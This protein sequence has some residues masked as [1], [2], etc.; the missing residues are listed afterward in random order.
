MSAFRYVY[1]RT[2]DKCAH[3]LRGCCKR[4]AAP[5]PDPEADLRG[6]LAE[7]FYAV[8]LRTPFGSIDQEGRG[9]FNMDDFARAFG[10]VASPPELASVFRLI[11]QDR[12]GTVTPSEWQAFHQRYDPEYRRGVPRHTRRRDGCPDFLEYGTLLD[13]ILTSCSRFPLREKL[14]EANEPFPPSE[15]WLTAAMEAEWAT[16]LLR[17][18]WGYARNPVPDLSEERQVPDW[19]GGFTVRDEGHVGMTN[20]DFCRTE[21]AVEA[22]LTMPEVVGLRLYT[23]PG[24]EA[25][26]L[27]LRA[28]SQRFPVTQYCIDSAIGKLAQV[29]PLLS[30]LRGMRKPMDPRWVRLYNLYRGLGRKR[31]A[32]S[33]PGFV[34]ATTDLAVATGQDFGGPLLFALHTM[35]PAVLPRAGFLSNGG[36]VQWVS[37]YPAEAEVLLP[38]NVILVPRLLCKHM[39]DHGLPVPADKSVFQFLVFFPWDFAH[40][41]PLVTTDF[42]ACANALLDHLHGLDVATVQTCRAGHPGGV[43]N[44]S[45]SR[46]PYPSVAPQ[47]PDPDCADPRDAASRRPPS[48]ATSPT[49]GALVQ[50][51]NHDPKPRNPSMFIPSV[52]P[53]QCIFVAPDLPSLPDPRRIPYSDLSSVPDPVRLL[54][55][56]RPTHFPRLSASGTDPALPGDH[57]HVAVAIP[58]PQRVPEAGDLSR[59]HPSLS[60]STFHDAIDEVTDDSVSLSFSDLSSDSYFLQP[61]HPVPTP[62]DALQGSDVLRLGR[63]PHYTLAE[64]EQAVAALQRR[65]RYSDGLDEVGLV[66]HAFPRVPA[67]LHPFLGSPWDVGWWGLIAAGVGAAVGSVGLSVPAA[68]GIAA[69]VATTTVVASAV[70]L[71]TLRSADPV[72]TTTITPTVTPTQTNPH[73]QTTTLSFTA[74]QT[75][76]GTHT[77]TASP[78]PTKPRTIS[79]TPT[80]SVTPSPSATRSP[81][82]SA[83]STRTVSQ[84]WTSSRTWIPVTSVSPVG[85]PFPSDSPSPSAN[86]SPSPPAS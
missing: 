49:K 48:P 45:L 28:N 29:G 3:F 27:S 10:W 65:P 64:V 39:R 42:L 51:I 32:L 54:R 63:V 5:D 75:T 40:N 72:R 7:H 73:S 11:N 76:S 14:A 24:Y 69:T 47:Q 83:S 30:L 81:T 1:Y 38:S 71:T 77:R 82:L 17:P 23:G 21:E 9:S 70:P 86:A 53:S 43:P 18:H 25:L 4:R 60:P 58:P 33:D 15:Q 12:S 46:P 79:V 36:D 6:R 41:C 61:V 67:L 66:G 52:D 78:S 85:S 57:P 22:G 20:E 62:P 19:T 55:H 26:N 35:A 44:L 80:R 31:L 68:A 56:L 50:Q 16:P 2:D 74:T 13:G 59:P 37:Q 34:S 84:T 8:L